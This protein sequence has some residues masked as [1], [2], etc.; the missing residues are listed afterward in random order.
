M[1]EILAQEE[2]FRTYGTII[3]PITQEETDEDE[4]VQ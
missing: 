2:N 4:T 3:N 1:D